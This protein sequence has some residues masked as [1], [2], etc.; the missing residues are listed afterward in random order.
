MKT[1]YG[2]HLYGTSTEKSDRDYKGIFLPTK[3]Q[4]LLGR[5][6]K[7]I[8]TT[9]NKGKTKNT[10]MDVDIEIYSL[11]Y[12]IELACQ[13]Q[14]V[15]LDMLHAPKEMLLVSTSL[16]EEIVKEKDRFY[17]KNLKAFMG[18]ARRQAAK[19]SI[20]G[21]RLNSVEEVIKFLKSMPEEK[22]LQDAWY[23][24]PQGEHIHFV[25][26]EKNN[27]LQYQVVGKKFPRT[28]RAGYMLKILEN[29]YE[30]YGARAQKAAR[31][32]GIDWKAISHAF[33]AAFEVEQ[34]LLNQD[35]K[36]PLPEAGFLLAVKK[37]ELDY[38]TEVLPKLEMLMD[39]IE[40]LSTKSSLPAKVDRK[41]WDRFLISLIERYLERTR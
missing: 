35:I 4:I 37:G 27:I 14:T 16:W 8:N 15:A 33:R 6:P 30:E 1:V 2:S 36:F 40:K 32:E 18:Y 21:S 9:P 7:S 29:F 11:H 22:K 5:I 28:V 17:T 25:N 3:E 12:F 13:G 23:K 10:S 19:Y 41:F 39:K 24:L 38:T 20:K 26:D 34:I 31:N